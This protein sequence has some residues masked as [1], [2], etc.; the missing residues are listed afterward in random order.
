[1]RYYFFFSSTIIV[2]F[3][4]LTLIVQGQIFTDISEFD[5]NDPNSVT[6]TAVGDVMHSKK[7]IWYPVFKRLRDIKYNPTKYIFKQADLAFV[8]LETPY[9]DNL[10]V[11]KKE[12]PFATDPIELK[13]LVDAGFNLLSMSN[14]HSHDAGTKGIRDTIRYLKNESNNISNKNRAFIWAGIGNTVTEAHRAKLFSVPGKNFRFA[15]L[16]YGNSGHHL[17]NT[18]SINRAV[19]EISKIKKNDPKTVIIVSLHNGNEYRHVP[20][21]QK[22]KSCR[23]LIN[24]GA[25]IIFGHHPHVVQ[26]IEKYKHGMIFYSLGNFSFGSKTDRHKKY[27]AKLHGMLVKM[28]ITR[29]AVGFESKVRIYPL[30]VDNKYPLKV[31]GQIYR[32][33]SFVPE[34]VPPPFSTVILKDIIR[35]SKKIPGNK[36][37][38]TLGKN[39]FETTFRTPIQQ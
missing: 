12:F 26:G 17:V 24:A 6:I 22:I 4:G 8:N 30:Y 14:N 39:Y 1:M 27:G 35:W 31:K 36:T 11:L 21:Y 9:T 38:F 25:S 13:Y 37:R 32:A 16:A 7:S 3:L 5:H 2:V 34:I 15:F 23:A 28:N 18:F 29:E 20:G 10:P 19:K 33:K